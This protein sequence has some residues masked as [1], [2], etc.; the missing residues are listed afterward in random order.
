MDGSEDS[1][2]IPNKSV[3]REEGINIQ[4]MDNAL[5]AVKQNDLIRKYDTRITEEEK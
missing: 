5:T 2:Q 3:N 4:Y 1:E